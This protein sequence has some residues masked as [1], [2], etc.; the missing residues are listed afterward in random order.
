MWCDDDLT[1]DT[2]WAAAAGAAGGSLSYVDPGYTTHS[3][4][5]VTIPTAHTHID[6]TTAL[7]QDGKMFQC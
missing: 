7:R 6:I 3:S 1:H 5:L 4:L 2:D